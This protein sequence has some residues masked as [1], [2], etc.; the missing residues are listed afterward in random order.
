MNSQGLSKF[1]M[2]GNKFTIFTAKLA[3]VALMATQ[4]LYLQVTNG[5]RMEAKWDFGREQLQ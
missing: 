2:A 1:K 3:K 5:M 4:P